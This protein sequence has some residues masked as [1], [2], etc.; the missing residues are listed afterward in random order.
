MIYG[1]IQPDFSRALFEVTKKFKP[2]LIVRRHDTSGDLIGERRPKSAHRG[3]EI[4]NRILVKRSLSYK[5]PQCSRCRAMPGH[6]SRLG[7]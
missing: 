6:N 5:T 3:H 2:S 1:G 7:G 4:G